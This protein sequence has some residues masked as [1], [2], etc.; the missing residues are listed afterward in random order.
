MNKT[1]AIYLSILNGTWLILLLEHIVFNLELAFPLA[2]IWGIGTL[3]F[4][5]RVIWKYA[6]TIT[7]EDEK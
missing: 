7:Y 2:M 6:V 3:L 1:D 4:N 5:I